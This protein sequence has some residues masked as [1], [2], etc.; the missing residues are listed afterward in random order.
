[1]LLSFYKQFDYSPRNNKMKGTCFPSSLE[2]VNNTTSNHHNN[3]CVQQFE[4][5]NACTSAQILYKKKSLFIPSESINLTQKKRKK[6]VIMNRP[7][8]V[9]LVVATGLGILSLSGPAE[10][11][12]CS[13]D[14]PAPNPPPPRVECHKVEKR[15]APCLHYIKGKSKH[16][17]KD[18]CRGVKKISKHVKTKADKKA[19]CKCIQRCLRGVDH[20]AKSCIP[21]IPKKCGINFTLPP[22]DAKTKC[23]KYVRTVNPIIYVL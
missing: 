9:F 22:V 13:D 1:M 15:F 20:Y 3:S 16:P 14:C 12:S 23:S 6:E 2:E 5:V 19:L 7:A 4:K 17:S 11:L 18:C 10:S 8:I 21:S